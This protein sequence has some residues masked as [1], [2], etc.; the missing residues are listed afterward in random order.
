MKWAN[1]DMENDEIMQKLHQNQKR[2]PRIRK[3]KSDWFSEEAI[4][5]FGAVVDISEDDD[6]LLTCMDR[7]K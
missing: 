3:D 7:I 1:L 6:Y 5:L 2:L 4:D